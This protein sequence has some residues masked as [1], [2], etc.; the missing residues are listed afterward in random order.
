LSRLADAVFLVVRVSV[1]LWPVQGL[2]GPAVTVMTV[3]GKFPQLRVLP[4]PFPYPLFFPLRSVGNLFGD[5]G[6]LSF[7]L[8]RHNL[9]C[10]AGQ[11]VFSFV[12]FFSPRLLLQW[13]QTRYPLFSP[14][15]SPPFPERSAKS[16][17]SELLSQ[18]PPPTRFGHSP[19]PFSSP[20]RG[21]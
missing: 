6:C 19:P 20:L 13:R 16:F 9:S 17:R 14:S 12:P 4:S 18:T 1:P 10:G 7:E 15:V 21:R 5:D 11:S 8:T 3:L 2:F